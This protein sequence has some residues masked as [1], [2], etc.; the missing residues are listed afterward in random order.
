MRTILRAGGIIGIVSFVALFAAQTSIAL[1]V[2]FGI[3]ASAVCAGLAVAKWLPREWYG[4]QFT[5]GLRA[6]A[7]ASGLAAAGSLASLLALGPHDLPTLI[8]R[9]HLLGV[10]AVS[11]ARA[12]QFADW[13]GVDVLAVLGTLAVSIV[14]AGIIT[15]IFAWGKSR[16]TVR[17]VERARQTARALMRDVDW[18][19]LSNGR[20]G[21]PALSM[22]GG[23]ALGQLTSPSLVGLSMDD[24]TPSLAAPGA[25]SGR[26]G[27]AA[28]VSVPPANR[29]RPARLVSPADSPAQRHTAAPAQRVSAAEAQPTRSAL[30]ATAASELTAAGTAEADAS[31]TVRRPKPRK[32]SR[33]RPADKQLSEA[34]RDAL[35]VW[36]EETKEE[37]AEG[38]PARRVAQPSAYLNSSGPAPKR[39]KRNDT[40]DWL[41]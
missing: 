17:V 6:G 26:R 31:A 24:L 1:A 32:S 36:A 41:C 22:T 11:L 2:V 18:A 10:D 33:A 14:L 13:A 34:M 29:V 25:R 8:A 4:H 19:P 40:R 27:T 9:S 37:D 5:A 23:P 3:L 21:A 16:H 28:P 20:T 38:V 12:L 35:A 39:R 15:L 7:L 30:P